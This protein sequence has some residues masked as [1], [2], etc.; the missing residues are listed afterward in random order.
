M[1]SWLTGSFGTTMKTPRVS[2][3][4]PDAKE[5]ALK[6]PLDQMPA[7]EK[8]AA[9]KKPLETKPVADE[10]QQGLDELQV[11]SAVFPDYSPSGPIAKE[12]GREAPVPSTA[13]SLTEPSSRNPEIQKSRMLEFQKPSKQEIQNAGIPE[14]QKAGTLGS[15]KRGL[16]TKA[17]YRLSE[18]AL[19]A[20]GEAKR[21]LKRR[22]QLKVN[23]EEIVEV[24]VLEAF[25][26]LEEK[27]DKSTLVS[28]FSGKPENKKS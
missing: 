1:M 23:M 16:Y 12:K 9:P 24:A 7:I 6:S 13:E 2:D 19:D 18:E 28:S 8:P 14:T 10:T 21:I 5:R 17:T 3:F 20:I 4:D 15:A 26:D 25:K 11:G 22:Y 27:Q